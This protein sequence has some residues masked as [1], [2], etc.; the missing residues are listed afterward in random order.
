MK[1]SIDF[2][3]VEILQKWKCFK[4]SGLVSIFDAPSPDFDFTYSKS[5]KIGNHRLFQIYSEVLNF[6]SMM[7]SF[8]M[9]T[10]ISAISDSTT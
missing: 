5:P 9:T 2:I 3:T 7:K 8:V 4:I 1:I 10:I 6:V